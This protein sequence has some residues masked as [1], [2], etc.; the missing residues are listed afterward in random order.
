[1]IALDA[2]LRDRLVRD[3]AGKID[4]AFIAGDGGTPTGTE[5]LG[6]LS[7][8]GT[9]EMLAVG[10]IALDDLHDAVG[11]AMAAYV[12]TSRLRWLTTSRDFVKLRKI[13]DLQERYQLQPD[14]TQ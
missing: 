9:Q 13:K 3:V 11:L 7:Y 12:D 10:A 2:A 4:A 14:P 1:V 5:P 6:L 8:P